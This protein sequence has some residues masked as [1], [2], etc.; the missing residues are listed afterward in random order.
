MQRVV[1]TDDTGTEQVIAV[2]GFAPDSIPNSTDAT[3]SINNSTWILQNRASDKFKVWTETTLYDTIPVGASNF[4]SDEPEVFVQE[5]DGS[6]WVNLFRGYLKS[7]G[8]TAGDGSYEFTLHD[9][10]KRTGSNQASVGPI[11]DTADNI[12]AA[13]LPSGYSVETPSGVTPPTLEDYSLNDQRKVGYRDLTEKVGWVLRFT[14]RTD[15]SGNYIVRYEPEGHGSPITTLTG[16]SSGGASKFKEWENGDTD[17]VINRVKV[18]GNDSDGN[19]VVGFAEDQNSIDEYGEKFKPVPVDFN[20][21]DTSTAETIAQSYL[22]LEPASGGRVKVQNG[23]D[24]AVVNS[25]FY[26]EDDRRNLDSSTEYTAVKQKNY[27]PEGSTELDFT[28]EKESER[29]SRESDDLRGERSE[30]SENNNEDVGNQDFTGDTGSAPSDTGKAGGVNDNA[31]NT[32]TS[33]G[34]QDSSFST[35]ILNSNLGTTTVA[36]GGGEE[37][38]EL[39]IPNYSGNL[40]NISVT[41]VD[42]EQAHPTTDIAVLRYASSGAFNPQ[43]YYMEERTE[44]TNSWNSINFGLAGNAWKADITEGENVS[45]DYITVWIKNN[46]S[47]SRDYIVALTVTT[48][49]THSHP[50]DI[51]TV[52][53][54]HGHGDN[55]TTTDDPHGGTGDPTGQHGTSGT[56]DPKNI[57]VTDITRE[58]R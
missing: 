2:Q 11:T 28:F 39:Q 57:D 19:K 27:Y 48:E 51:V 44:F 22:Q 36:G 33:G 46:S 10:S 26:L 6:S 42:S 53:D 9:H 8:G 38:A 29:K 35:S 54:L 37:F 12:L 14:P 43:F 30:V 25:S 47:T 41:V 58:D 52:D 32:G 17:T 13:L 55:I 49:N 16:Q 24:G 45:G 15:G 7:K 31:S 34:V 18:F 3:A 56:T 1:Y 40:I 23:F 21:P 5:Y 20:I 50:D 4:Q